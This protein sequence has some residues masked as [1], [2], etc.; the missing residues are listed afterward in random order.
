MLIATGDAQPGNNRLDHEISAIRQALELSTI[1]VVERS[2]AA[3]SELA[4][5]LTTERPTI[6]HLAAH[7]AHGALAFRL[8]GYTHW[9]DQEDIG[10]ALRHGPPPRIAVLN[11]CATYKLA[12]EIAEWCPAVV[13]WPNTF[14][15]DQARIFSDGFYRTLARGL[16]VSVATAAGHHIPPDSRPRMIGEPDLAP[17][18]TDHD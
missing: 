15:D 11:S 14:D 18:P 17:F 9:V 6:L 3:P 12:I 2:C 16:P 8:D 13:Y 1:H 10:Q 5:F 7:T 4:G